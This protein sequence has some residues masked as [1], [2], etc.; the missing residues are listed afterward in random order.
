[1]RSVLEAKWEQ[2]QDEWHF[3]IKANAFLYHMVRK[4]VFSQVAV[5]KGKISRVDLKNALE[6][7]GELPSGIAP[8]NG[9]NL[10]EVGYY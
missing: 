10:I 2:N 6:G 4:I 1:V 7:K 3:E 8:P 5:G 9:L